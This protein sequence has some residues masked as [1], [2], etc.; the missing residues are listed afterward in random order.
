[1]VA[2][3]AAKLLSGEAPTIFGDGTHTRDYI[4][5]DDVADAFVRATDRASGKLLNIGT[6]IETSVN[7]I[8]RILARMTRF[9]GTPVHGPLPDGEV[10]RSCLDAS[11]ASRELGWKPRIGLHDGLERTVRSFTSL[12]GRPHS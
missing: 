8:Y 3:F 4:F 6:G 5:V 7:D 11:R 9:G 1:V 12:A 2:I 10:D